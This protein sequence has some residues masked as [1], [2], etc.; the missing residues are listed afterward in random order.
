MHRAIICLCA[1]AAFGLGSAWAL[2]NR[3]IPTDR[4]VPALL[5]AEGPTASPAPTRQDFTPPL[6]P[7]QVQGYSG[8]AIIR[9][10]PELDQILNG[11]PLAAPAPA[12]RAAPL[13]SNLPGWKQP[14]TESQFAAVATALAHSPRFSDALQRLLQ[15]GQGAT[16]SHETDPRHPGQSRY[17]YVTGF[18]R[19][20]EKLAPHLFAAF[21]AARGV[22]RQNIIFQVALCLPEPTCQP[23]LKG[24]AAGSDTADADDASCALAFTG[25][26][27]AITAFAG[28]PVTDCNLLCDDAGEHDLLA[29]QGKRE[30]LRSYRCIELL[31]CRPY[32]WRHCWD[33]GRGEECPFPWADRRAQDTVDQ[34]TELAARLLP[35][36]L[37][38]F[39][40]HPG[41]DDMAWR[42]CQHCKSQQQW[43]EAAQWASRC[44]TMP[45]QDVCA[46]GLSDLVT[47]AER[48][49]APSSL[50][51]LLQGDDWQ[52]NR[53]LVQYIRLRRCAA[54]TGFVD[55]LALAARMAQA[56]P[57]SLL[58]RCFAARWRT[59]VPKGLESGVVALPADDLLRRVEPGAVP[60]QSGFNPQTRWVNW[61]LMTNRGALEDAARLHPPADVVRLPGARLA[62]QFRL[63]ETMAELQRRRDASAGD[64]QADLAYKMG[65]VYYHQ[66]FVV[67]PVY[68]NERCN[69]GMPAGISPSARLVS[70]ADELARLDF[71]SYARAATQFE[72]IADHYPGWQGHDK[73]LYSAALARIKLV[74]YRPFPGF[75]DRDI[76]AAVDLFDRLVR[77]HPQSGLSK[78]GKDAAIYWRRM[79]PAL[80]RP[81]VSRDE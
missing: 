57:D 81:V 29:D 34:R 74:D 8:T 62:Q 12:P 32:F 66:S 63:W 30:I 37:K 19:Q 31:D 48:E 7:V 15:L 13:P 11:K 77:D 35:H 73:A 72:D 10:T 28:G 42:L 43:F 40:G 51:E 46:A 80:F 27:A 4:P 47:L 68:A 20:P 64:E 50:E 41:S 39:A 9:A 49:L 14:A 70:R 33:C 60:G 76:A 56:E 45:D 53:E 75:A 2:L 71:A 21:E 6:N 22:A 69:N 5:A 1:L 65:A 67:Y 78:S 58:A 36:W 23:W 17:V 59:G 24:L 25:D 55:A 18:Q 3:S 61:Y 54:E 16:G 44:A 52:R 79:R 26:Q 38:R